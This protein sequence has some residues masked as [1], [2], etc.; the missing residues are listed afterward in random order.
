M[1]VQLSGVWRAESRSFVE[2]DY[3]IIA[4]KLS[5]FDVQTL[6]IIFHCAFQREPVLYAIAITRSH[7]RAQCWKKGTFDP[8]AFVFFFFFLI[9]P[10]R[11]ALLSQRNGE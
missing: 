3:D 9:F 7:S 2:R 4:V 5:C 8:D 11:T 6:C 1:I 10:S